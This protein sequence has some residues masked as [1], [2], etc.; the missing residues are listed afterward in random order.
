MKQ[1][2]DA[3]EC[4]NQALALYK[5]KS[6]QSIGIAHVLHN[7]GCL[8]SDFLN[9]MHTQSCLEE[10]LNIY[11]T[12]SPDHPNIKTIQHM[13]GGTS[14]LSDK[15]QQFLPPAQ[16]TITSEE[17]KSNSNT[18]DTSTAKTPTAYTSAP[19]TEADN[20]RVKPKRKD[21]KHCAIS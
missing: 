8:Y 6:T 3:E 7:L 14:G 16:D 2:D 4:F 21:K 19:T 11:T 5:H 15:A 17:P 9:D 1:L 18:T 10:A 13:L 20:G 12:L